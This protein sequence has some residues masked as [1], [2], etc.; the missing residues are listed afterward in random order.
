[1]DPQREPRKVK[2]R[3]GVQLQASAYFD[4]LTLTEMLE[5]L[6]RFYGKALNPTEILAKV[7]L[8]EKAKSTVKTLSGGQ[9]QRFSIAATLVNDPELVFLDEPTT[10]LD[11]QARRNLWDLVRQVHGEG[12][13]VVLTTHYM[14]EAEVLCNR[15]AIMDHGKLV[16]LDRPIDLIHRLPTPYQVRV[17]S[18]RPLSLDALRGL[19][20][21]K[22]ATHERDGMYALNVGDAALAVP[23]LVSWA[24]QEAVTFEHLEVR[25]ATLDDVFLALTGRQLRD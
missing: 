4:F 19:P 25:P 17:Q 7:G 9:Q 5:L 21:V 14:E 24:R 3:I 22:D 20:S 11:P 10:G 18:V 16:A 2:A 23:A 1:M 12:R 13:T 8:E 6:G 15:V